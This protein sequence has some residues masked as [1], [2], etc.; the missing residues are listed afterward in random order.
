M[1]RRLRS[2]GACRPTTPHAARHVPRR[3][4]GTRCSPFKIQRSTKHQVRSY[5]IP[6][7]WRPSAGSSQSQRVGRSVSQ[8]VGRSVSPSVSQSRCAGH[9]QSGRRRS[10]SAARWMC[11]GSTASSAIRRRREERKRSLD[12]RSEHGG[13]TGRGRRPRCEPG[14]AG[15]TSN[16]LPTVS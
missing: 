9:K 1:L 13:G 4:K 14:H 2:T 11:N 3:M 7:P 8:S 10:L 16:S 5:L 15:S 6:F 12:R